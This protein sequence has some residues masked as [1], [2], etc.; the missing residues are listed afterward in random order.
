MNGSAS[1]GFIFCSGTPL[2]PLG[3]GLVIDPQT[4][5]CF[6]GH[7]SGKLPKGD[8]LE[9]LRERVL[10]AVMEMIGKGVDTFITGMAQGFDLIA[11]QTVLNFYAR[12]VLRLICAVPYFGQIGEMKTAEE[13]RVYKDLLSEA[14]AKVCF[15][16]NYS[17]GVYRIRNQFMV[18]YSSHLIGYMDTC[19]SR[20]GTGQTLRMAQRAG[21]DMRVITPEE[22]VRT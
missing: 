9:I 19:G 22:L 17:S 10:V 2:L 8:E 7:R 20:S 3:C 16:E 21:L 18:N 12:P 1:N 5:C 11:A 14:Y 4:T 15:F 6:T 13:R